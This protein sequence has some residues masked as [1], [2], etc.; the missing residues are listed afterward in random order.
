ML[1]TLLPWKLGHDVMSLPS[2]AGDGT[3]E[4]CERWCCR[5]DLV[6]AQCHCRVMLAMVQPSHAGDGTAEAT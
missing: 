3:T 6:V 1:A 2:H 4:S 5:D